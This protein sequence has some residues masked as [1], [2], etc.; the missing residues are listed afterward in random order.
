[1]IPYIYTMAR[2]A[3][4]E[5]LSLC[6]PLYYD[7]PEAPESYS[8]RNE[9]LFGDNMLV[10]PITEPM[11]NGISTLEVW[12]PQGTWF[13]V[14]TGTMLQGGQTHVRNFMIDEYP[15]YVKAGSIIPQYADCHQ[16]VDGNEWTR[17]DLM[18]YPG[19]DGD[20]TMYYD[21]GDDKNYDANN[22]WVRFRATRQGNTYFANIYPAE[23]NYIPASRNTTLKFVASDVPQ[24]V[25]CNGKEIDWTYDGDNFTLV[26]P[27]PEGNW[28]DKT[29]IRVEYPQSGTINLTDGLIGNSHR[30]V[31][32]IAGLKNRKADIVLNDALGLMG[33]IGQKVSY[34]PETLH[35]SVT[36]FRQY[37][38]NLDQSLLDQGLSEEDQTWFKEQMGKK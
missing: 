3:H 1:M 16:H 28:E 11:E 34:F 35:E 19:A 31:K 27:L 17:F 38:D 5:G 7:W 8:F 30:A 12:L 22:M 20:F 2:K 14:S 37:F 26:V 4:D 9:Y 23:G 33:S 6:R 21:D 24:H 29:D 32:A 10:A 15:L 36:L 25:Y 18:I 13:E